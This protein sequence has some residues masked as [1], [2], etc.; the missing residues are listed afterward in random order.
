MLR[1]LRARKGDIQKTVDMYVAAMAFREGS[2]RG[3][4]LERD[5]R[6][7][8]LDDTLHRR[9]DSHWP[10]TAIL[11]RDRDGDF[12]YWNRIGL[13]NCDFLA[14]APVEFLVKHEVYSITRILQ[15]MEEQSRR[16]GRPT[17]YMTVV[18]D[19]SGLGTQHLN[20]KAL[21]K[22]KACVRCMEDNFPEMVKRIIVVR[23]P[24]IAFYLWKAC[25]V[26]FDEGTRSKVQIA[27]SDRTLS[28]LT[29]FIDEKWIPEALGG[30]NT[31]N[32][33]SW[34][35]P[36]IPAPCKPPSKDLLEAMSADV[37]RN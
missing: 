19:C 30:K 7:N 26:F 13:G 15:A 25:Q 37:E 33:H 3:Q 36:H 9:L 20:W 27:D 8:V 32:G 5:F 10:P 4:G 21:P 28:T 16:Q 35:F 2:G 11:G 1:F 6:L 29:Q 18:V 12:I 34:C 31:V 14:E 17:M 23:A 22:Y 24:R